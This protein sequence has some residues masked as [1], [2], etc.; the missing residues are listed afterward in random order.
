MVKL[1][2]Q[3]RGAK[4]KAFY[5]IVAMDERARRDGRFLEQLGHYDPRIDPPE[6]K[7]DIERVDHWVGLGAQASPTVRRIVN[8]VRTESPS[9]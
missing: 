2:L 9:A 3:R 1:R 4:K 7:L 6:I 8:R 5:R